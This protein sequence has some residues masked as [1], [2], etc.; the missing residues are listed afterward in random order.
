VTRILAIAAGLTTLAIVSIALL[1]MALYWYGLS[2]IPSERFRVDTNPV[3]EQAVSA[4]WLSLGG[5]GEPALD[6][7]N[8]HSYLS[9]LRHGTREP[10]RPIKQRSAERLG[11][12]ASHAILP[13]GTR[14]GSGMGVWHLA[15]ASAF[16]WAGRNWSPRQAIAAYLHQASFG[17]GFTGLEA[18]AMGYFD[19]APERLTLAHYAVLIATMHSARHDPW[20]N[21]REVFLATQEFLPDSIPFSPPPNVLP[22]PPGACAEE[23]A[24]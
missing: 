14:I 19:R 20:C 1:P 10:E 23:P 7:R 2:R 9:E 17:H 21:P 5:T 24:A 12:L 3:P 18:A 4:F 6:Q 15:R 16:I 13:R 8:P 22:A 11:V